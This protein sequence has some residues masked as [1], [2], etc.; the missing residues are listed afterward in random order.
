MDP[1][2]MNMMNQK[3]DMSLAKSKS[4]PNQSTSIFQPAENDEYT[5][6]RA[7]LTQIIK[8]M[9]PNDTRMSCQSS[10]LIIQLSMN[11]LHYISDMSNNVCNEEGKKTIT[12]SH[13]AKALKDLKMDTYLSQILQLGIDEGN[14]VS[15]NEK[16]TK[17]IISQK[18]MGNQGGKKKKKR[19]G[20]GG[21]DNGMTE[22]EMIAE[23][24]RLFQKAID[25][26]YDDDEGEN[27][28]DYQGNAGP[29]VG[30]YAGMTEE[31]LQY[32]QTMYEENQRQQIFQYEQFQQQQF[33][34]QMQHQNGIQ[35]D[36]QVN[37][38]ASSFAQNIQANQTNLSENKLYQDYNLQMQKMKSQKEVEEMNFDEDDD[39]N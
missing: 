32:A 19:G 31:Q 20:K 33:Q 22:E 10:D 28:A 30:Q 25:Y 16:Q 15:L 6:P 14:E 9:L 2:N 37:T 26:D 4:N 38:N 18:M 1:F 13:V 23:Q 11:F 12:P 35:P 39:E 5:L 34:L 17:D 27:G 3:F 8:E 36:T 21:F 29:G 7:T 24:K